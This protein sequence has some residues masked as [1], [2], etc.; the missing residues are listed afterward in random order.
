VQWVGDRLQRSA[1]GRKIFKEFRAL[2][3]RHGPLVPRSPFAAVDWQMRN[4]AGERSVSPC[5]KS[6]YAAGP[7]PKDKPTSVAV[8][9]A[10]GGPC[11]D[12]RR[13]Q[14]VITFFA[15]VK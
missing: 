4:L 15:K 10:I 2:E 7:I 3:G 12:T 9:S 6:S 8:P 5:H 14:A 13:G 1:I 11:E